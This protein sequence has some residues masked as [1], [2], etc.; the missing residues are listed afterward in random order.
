MLKETYEGAN[1]CQAIYERVTNGRNQPSSFNVQ[2][3]S[4]LCHAID[5]LIQPVQILNPVRTY[6]VVLSCLLPNRLLF[7]INT[8][9]KRDI[10]LTW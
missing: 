5:S 4:L 10:L 1:M 9:C 7:C 8:Q 6:I 2:E 3:T